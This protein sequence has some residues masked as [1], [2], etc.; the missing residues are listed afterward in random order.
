MLVADMAEIR[1][2]R[3]RLMRA[4]I[5]LLASQKR[6]FSIQREWKKANYGKGSNEEGKTVSYPQMGL[7]S[8]DPSAENIAEIIGLLEDLKHSVETE[9]F[10]E[11]E[12]W[13]VQAVYGEKPSYKGRYLMNLLD[14]APKWVEGDPVRY[15]PEVEVSRG[16]IL[17][18]LTREITLFQKLADLHNA[19]DDK[20]AEALMDGQLI[21]SQED[22]R[23]IMEYEAALERQF[24]RKL[25]QLVAWRR[26]KG[27]VGE[28]DGA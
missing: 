5:G 24:E 21:P 14:R 1:W 27:E 16:P 10:A 25:Q 26:S 19:S 15:N 6:E 2:R 9:G 11:G 3:Q 7:V 17:K 20:A 23:K 13:R 18:T 8:L 28:T 22:L 12:F 4:E